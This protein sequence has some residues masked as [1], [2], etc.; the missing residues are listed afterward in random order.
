M[1]SLS[2]MFTLLILEQI[3]KKQHDIDVMLHLFSIPLII[4]QL[5]N[6]LQ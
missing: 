1:T 3:A 2:L 4:Y 5:N 6:Y